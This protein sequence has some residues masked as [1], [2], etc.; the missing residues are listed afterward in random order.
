MDTLTIK[1]S[2]LRSFGE[3]RDSTF[4]LV[5]GPELVSRFRIE[6]GARYAGARVV[7]YTGEEPFE[8]VLAREIP[9]N[10]H[11]LVILPHHYFKS[12]PPAALGER[13]KLG[14]LACHSTPTSLDAIAHFV[15]MGEHT[16]P[17]R[18]EQMASDFFSR[19]QAAER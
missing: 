4:C 17:D 10:A 7:P 2:N 11:V 9:E 16:D 1:A 19:G 12:P 3:S 13:R 6:P 5:T 15:A 14:V 8:D 18:Q